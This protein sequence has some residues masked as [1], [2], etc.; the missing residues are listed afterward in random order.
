MIKAPINLQDQRLLG[1]TSRRRQTI[2]PITLDAKCAGARSTGNPH[3]ACDV[4]GA[5]NGITDTPN[6]A[7]RNLPEA[8]RRNQD[9]E[10]RRAGKDRLQ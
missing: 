2:G 1:Y 6:Q 8:E 5:G 9:E 10:S 7:R 3:A 4:A